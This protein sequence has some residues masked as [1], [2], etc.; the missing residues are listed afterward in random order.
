MRVLDN[1]EKQGLVERR[2]CDGDKRVKEIHLTDA[3]RP[4]IEKITL[5]SAE[6]RE[7]VLTDVPD[8]KL[9]GAL[10]VLRAIGK[11]LEGM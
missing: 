6:L 9:R 8:E 2:T 11:Q 7:N 10:A 5:I 3:A 4:A 1:L